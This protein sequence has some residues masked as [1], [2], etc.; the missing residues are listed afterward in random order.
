M[1]VSSELLDVH[2]E[3]QVQVDVVLVEGVS[4]LLLDGFADAADL[5]VPL[6]VLARWHEQQNV[7][8]HFLLNKKRYVGK[9]G[10]GV[11]KCCPLL[12]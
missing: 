4:I 6:R 5:D 10:F 8:S 7:L 2:T 3:Q 12:C 11:L 1:L 9:A